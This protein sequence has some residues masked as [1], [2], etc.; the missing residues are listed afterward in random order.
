MSDEQSK[1]LA[2]IQ[3][4]ARRERALA[5][6]QGLLRALAVTGVACAVALLLTTTNLARGTATGWL[7]LA[8]LLGVVLWALF[9]TARALQDAADP[10]RQARL[11]EALEPKLRGRLVTAVG[12]EEGT[13]GQESEALLQLVT[14]RALKMARRVPAQTVHPSAP[15]RRQGAFALGAYVLAGLCL[16]IIPGGLPGALAWWGTEGGDRVLAELDDVEQVEEVARVGNLTIRYIYPAYMERE[17]YEVVNSTGDVRAP[18]GTRVEVIART[19]DAMS[20][21]GLSVDGGPVLEAELLSERELRGS[22]VIDAEMKEYRIITV[23]DGTPQSSKPYAISTEADLPPEVQWIADAPLVEVPIDRPLQLPWQATDDHALREVILQVY[24]GD[25]LVSERSLRK[26]REVLSRLE[27][28]AN[29]TPKQLD[30]EV[31]ETYEL[32][33]V[34]WDRDEISGDK[35]GVSSRVTLTVLDSRGRARMSPVVRRELLDALLIALAGHLESDFDPTSGSRR[36]IRKWGETVHARTEPLQAILEANQPG[37]DLRGP[38]QPVGFALSA[39]TSFVRYTQV[40]FDGDAPVQDGAVNKLVE[41]YD[42]VILTHEEAALFLDRLD[43]NEAA[44][45]LAEMISRLE[46]DIGTF[47]AQMEKREL[48]E[49]RDALAQ[50]DEALSDLSESAEVLGRDALNELVNTRTD[51]MKSMSGRLD[52]LMAQDEREEASEQ[53]SRLVQSM[54]ELG[55]AYREEMERRKAQSE[56]AGQEAAELKEE[57]KRLMEA[58]EQL[59]EQLAQERQ[60]DKG[61]D[62]DKLMA[63]W[64]QLEELTVQIDERA[65]RYEESVK[66]ADR[67]FIEERLAEYASEGAAGLPASAYNRDLQGVEEG[68][69]ALSNVWMQVEM[70]HETLYRDGEP[71]GLGRREQKEIRGLIEEALSVVEQLKRQDRTSSSQLIQAMRQMQQAQATL[72]QELQ[73]AAADAQRVGQEMP[74][75]PRGMNEA[76]AEADLRMK[77]ASEA[78]SGSNPMAAEGGQRAAADAIQRA[79]DA[80]QDAMDRA[81]QSSG[82]EGEEDSEGKD[83]EESGEDS[84]FR[85]DLPEPDAFQ[86]PEAYRRALMQ[87]MQAEVPEEYRA[88][89]RRYFEELVRQ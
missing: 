83:G 7:L 89:K 25:E 44:R 6:W 47:E 34:A 28:E 1:T 38:W 33:A 20:S 65:V 45:A 70:R 60:N 14:R 22:F 51:V 75:T 85:I 50:I 11:V 61:T 86:T 41:L 69:E 77:G 52:D 4:L 71:Q 88:L 30:L 26:P 53:A 64:K 39:A 46:T 2:L 55:S 82:Q 58:Q 81:A 16:L 23:I 5:L 15:V 18:T 74:I 43:Q 9:P 66:A 76:L 19:A 13:W 56:E 57:L 8:W 27:G 80:L 24:R 10:M 49:Q 21:A 48:A 17:P 40:G 12:H 63:L 79:L 31:G 3:E 42:E 68:L 35:S 87:G 37:R 29:V 73:S 72:N 32:Q 62:Q 78:L 67:T 59:A 54:R 36:Q 84:T